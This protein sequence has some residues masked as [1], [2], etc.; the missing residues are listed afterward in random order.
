MTT[1]WD[2]RYSARSWPPEPSPTVAGALA[3]A[4]ADLP[5]GRAVDVAA[6]PGRHTRW[7]LDRGWSVTAVDSSA[8]GVEQG[9]GRCPEATWVV[10]DALTWTPVGGVDLVLAAYVQLGQ[11]GFARAA[12]WLVPGGRLVVVGHALSG[13]ARSPHGPR[14]P[15]MRHT[16]EAL[17]AAAAGLD[18][19]R[20]EEVERPDDGGPSVDVVLVAR[21]PA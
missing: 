12:G 5:P 15:A 1:D 16:P 11:A 17:R 7:L 10:A 19:E 13:L 9:Q 8:V 6:G 14:D 20:A 2:A 21:R 4:L 3:D 18:V